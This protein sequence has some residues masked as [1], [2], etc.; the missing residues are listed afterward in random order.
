MLRQLNRLTRPLP[1]AG[2][3][4]AAIAVY[5]QPSASGLETTV[6]EPAA[7]QGFE[8]VACVDDAARAVV[9]YC[10]LWER[11]RTPRAQERALRLL[12]FLAYMQDADGRFTNFILDW[13]GRK[14]VAGS[15]SKAGAGPWQARGLHALA[16]AVATFESP[17]WEE[18]FQRSLGWVECTPAMDTLAV[19]TLAVLRH[20][21][22]TQMA[23]SAD[24]AL[25]WS[26]EIAGVRAADRLLNA[27]DVTDVHLWGHLQEAALADTG[28]LLD[29]PALV[30]TARA[31][32][33]ALL[34]PALKWSQTAREVQPF[35]VS[36]VVAGLAAVGAATHERGYH[37]AAGAQR[38]WF[39]GQNAAGTPVYN[40]HRGLVHDGIDE[41]RVSRNSGA[42]SN[43]EGA[44][45]LLR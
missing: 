9:L 38:A 34:L 19:S 3:D 41:A 18:R 42:E 4:A 32:A 25:A 44:L 21:R 6:L 15:S 37:A 35:D 30:A 40:R 39:Y 14:N 29:Q 12:R 7:E 45:A 27:A 1:A 8:G 33:D 22:T 28:R 23:P 5:A 43:I 2:P 26:K 20:W 11:Y 16:W 13:D 36:S 10:E 24:R 17:E 31:S